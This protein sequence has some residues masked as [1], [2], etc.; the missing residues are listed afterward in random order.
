M[1]MEL[2]LVQSYDKKM[3]WRANLYLDQ[4]EPELGNR[5]WNDV[6]PWV[7]GNEWNTPAAGYTGVAGGQIT[8]INDWTRWNDNETV[9]GNVAYGWGAWDSVATFNSELAAQSELISNARNE[10]SGDGIF[11]GDD[12]AALQ[13]LGGTTA[14]ADNWNNYVFPARRPVGNHYVYNRLL[15]DAQ[16]QAAQDVQHDYFINGSEFSIPGL[17]TYLD[18][19]GLYNWNQVERTSGIDCSGLAH[20]IALYRGSPYWISANR[21]DTKLGTGSFAGTTDPQA[22]LQMHAGGWQLHLPDGSTPAQCSFEQNTVP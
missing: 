3:L 2:A 4:R 5:D 7:T 15:T 8:R 21:S 1:L 13:W 9:T 10:N 11:Q 18:D 17:S 22:T 19:E 16:M 12:Y 14:P 6:H 20:R